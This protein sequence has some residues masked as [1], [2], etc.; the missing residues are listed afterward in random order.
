MSVPTTQERIARFHELL[1]A[2]VKETRCSLDVGVALLGSGKMEPIL[3][4]IP[5][6]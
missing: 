5:M 6:E 3:K 1:N 4:V 2:A